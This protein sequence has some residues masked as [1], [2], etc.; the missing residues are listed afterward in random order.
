MSNAIAGGEDPFPLKK[1][2]A[3]DGDPFPLS[4]KTEGQTIGRWVKGRG[5]YRA[6]QVGPFVQLYASGVISHRNATAHLVRSP[7]TVFPPIYG[8][9]FFIPEISLPQEEPFVTTAS[10]FADEQ[11]EQLTVWDT[12]GRH[13]IKV[14]QA[15]M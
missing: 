13:D 1:L 8:L 15:P 4:I 11:V 6:L 9:F 2:H 10:F 14:H 5:S 7:L 12:D 3:G